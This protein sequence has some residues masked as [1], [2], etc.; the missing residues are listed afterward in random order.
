MENKMNELKIKHCKQILDNEIT[1]GFETNKIHKIP[2]ISK[3]FTFNPWKNEYTVWYNEIAIDG[4]QALEEL[5]N[6][7]NDLD[8][9][10]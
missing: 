3:S 1:I 9:L 2:K 6:V 8:V 4:G 7:Y 10:D 5:L